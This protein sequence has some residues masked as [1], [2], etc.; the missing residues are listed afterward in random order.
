M[1]V[2]R[3]VE[4]PAIEA[5]KLRFLTW[6]DG[7]S[8]R[9]KLLVGTLGALLAAVVLVYGIVKPLQA[10]RAESLA[11]IRTYETLDARIRAAGS[12]GPSSATPPRAGSPVEVLTASAGSFGLQ[13]QIEATPGGVR[14]TLTD[15]DYG[16]VV[17]WM[18]DVA[19][20]TT[21]ATTRVELRRLAGP[22]RVSAI[23]EYRP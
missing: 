6:W 18:A 10:S 3:I 12:L 13:P 9:E 11:E 14:A 22:G 8:S 15:A 17:N 7:L 21:L 16:A 1:K 4:L 5:A 23:V 2:T 20:T 19:R